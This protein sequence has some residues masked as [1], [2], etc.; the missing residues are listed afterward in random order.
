[1]QEDIRVE[2]PTEEGIQFDLR[3]L[4]LGA[5]RTTLEAL[6]EEEVRRIAG[7]G[8]WARFQGTKDYR[9]GT[10]MRGLMTSLGHLA[11]SIPRTRHSGSAAD[12]IGRYKRRMNEIDDGIVAAYVGGISTRKMGAVTE[13]LMGDT[14]DKSTISRITKSL[15]EKVEALRT[16]RLDEAI[17]YLYLDATFID[18]RW[19]RK[20]ENVAA[21]VA[22]GIGPDGKRRL[23]AVTL[24]ASESE[25]S[26]T[27]M[28]R[29]LL[30]RGLHGVKLII[31]DAHPG[32]LAAARHLLPEVPVQRC[33][34][35]LERNILTQTPQRLRLRLGKELSNVFNAPSLK[36]A[37]E[38]KEALK[39]GL[40]AQLPEAMSCLDAGFS[41]AT[42]FYS[43]P[44]AHWRRIKTTNG[45]ERLNAEIKRRTRAVGAFPDRSSA[46]RLIT[47]VAL[48][49]TEIWSDRMYLDMTAF[50]SPQAQAA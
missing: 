1:M 6:L 38:R 20:V 3:S 48:S 25:D 37:R 35:H 16:S 14:V 17:I 27:E 10:Y 5:V 28:L 8:S 41:S 40:G 19:A 39:H 36:E 9:N 42:T 31:A 15:E 30:A 49:V 24:G 11:V 47:A 50:N 33:V 34:V 32:L 7:N 29:Q 13:A 18:A 2:V 4:F 22:Y 23:L 46:L 45:L 12:V 44:K 43:F 26:W 21:L